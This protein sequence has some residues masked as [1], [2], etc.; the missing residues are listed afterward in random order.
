MT[1][2]NALLITMDAVRAD[3]LSCYGFAG[4]RT[5]HLD[6]LATQGVRFTNAITAANVTD[7]SHV[8]ILTSTYPTEHG[9][10]LNAVRFNNPMPTLPEVLLGH[11]YTTMAAVSVEHLSSYFGLDRGFQTFFNNSPFDRLYYFIALRPL[12]DQILKR[13]R[14]WRHLF[15]RSHWRVGERT[16]RDVLGWLKRHSKTPFF[17]WVH[18]FD[19]HNYPD[20]PAYD[21]KVRYVDSQIGQIV[22]ELRRLRVFSQTAIVVVSDHGELLQKRDGRLWTHGQTLLDLELRVP[23]IISPFPESEGLIV[24]DQVRTIDIAPTVLDL[25]GFPVPS[26]WRGVSLLPWMLGQPGDDLT[27][28]AMSCGL[29]TGAYCIRTGSWKYIRDETDGDALYDLLRDPVERVNL[30]TQEPEI[31]AELWDQ[32]RELWIPDTG[33]P[34]TEREAMAIQEMLRDLGYLDE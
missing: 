9:V 17:A 34:Y 32:L 23:L 15:R 30:I 21:A 7:P 24:S 4:H 31:A 6:A 1:L 16:T 33:E 25:L 12:L 19:A 8:S 2:R 3:R 5:P 11:G 28:F 22:E 14:H 29:K 26:T 13:L 27:A 10:R 20:L 18:Y